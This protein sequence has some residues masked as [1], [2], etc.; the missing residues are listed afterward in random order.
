MYIEAVAAGDQYDGAISLDNMIWYRDKF[1][2]YRDYSIIATVLVYVLNIIDANVFAYFNDFDISDDIT[3]N[4]EP[5]FIDNIIPESTVSN[6][7]YVQSVG[8]KINM[9]F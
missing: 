3:L 6:K 2:R 9:N 1:R 7:Y 5:G 8:L 4:V